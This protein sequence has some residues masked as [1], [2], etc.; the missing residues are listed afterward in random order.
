MTPCS[1]S[2]NNTVVVTLNFTQESGIY[3]SQMLPPETITKGVYV[4][5][6]KRQIEEEMPPEQR[7]GDKNCL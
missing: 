2:L 7:M 5:K 6:Q 4:H 1:R 3:F